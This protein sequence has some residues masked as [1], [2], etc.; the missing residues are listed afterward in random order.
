MRESLC[1]TLPLETCYSVY[2]IFCSTIDSIGGDSIVNGAVISEERDADSISLNV[3]ADTTESLSLA[4]P[5]AFYED[6][7]FE[8]ALRE[9][10]LKTGR[11]VSKKPS[12]LSYAQTHVFP[13]HLGHRT[14]MGT[15]SKSLK[16]SLIFASS[17]RPMHQ[18][19]QKAISRCIVL[20]ARFY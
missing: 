11:T 4:A 15:V 1:F 20:Y 9:A 12:S 5:R 19:Q 6:N 2:F 3:L 14:S 10:C 13:P 16:V 8:R 18:H 7:S 17:R